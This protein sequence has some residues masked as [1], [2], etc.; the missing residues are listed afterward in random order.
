MKIDEGF[1]VN[2]LKYNENSIIA[3]FYTRENGRTSGIIFGGMS[4][5]IK[6]YLE[7]GNYFHLNLNSKND[8][9]IFSI[10]AEILKAYTPIYF[11]NQ[12]KLYCIVSA[13]SL[14]KNLTPENEENVEIFNLIKNLFN[15]LEKN[16]WLKNY[17]NW[18]LMLLKYLGYDLNLKNIVHKEN[19]KNNEVFYVKSSTQKKIVPNF[20]I[21]ENIENVD[22][23]EILKGFTIVSNYME[24]N[25][26]SP[27]NMKIPTQRREFENLLN[28]Q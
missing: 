12:K 28:K 13:M 4:K 24:K 25:I 22:Y 8:S 15:I 21:N 3:D 26:F 6:G 2:K 16:N 18:E 23:I 9:K 17:V 27:N 5:K 20:L 10:K 7:I 11:N 14:I 19:V 1:L